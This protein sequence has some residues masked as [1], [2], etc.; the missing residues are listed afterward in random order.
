MTKTEFLTNIN[1]LLPNGIVIGGE[2]MSYKQITIEEYLE[3]NVSTL[4]DDP[5]K[6]CTDHSCEWGT[7]SQSNT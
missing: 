1:K 4:D 5:C 7:C 3:E 2:L 6:D